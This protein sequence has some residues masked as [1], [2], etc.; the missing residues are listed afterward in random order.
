MTVML[1]LTPIWDKTR[2]TSIHLKCQLTFNRP[3]S[4]I[5]QKIE[6]LF[7]WQYYI[8]RHPSPYI[9]RVTKSTN[10]GGHMHWLEGSHVTS[11]FPVFC[12]EPITEHPEASHKAVLLQAI[13]LPFVLTSLGSHWIRLLHSGN[14]ADA[15][16]SWPKPP[17]PT[18]VATASGIW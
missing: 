7:S 5:S 15:T 10:W 14:V 8:L 16:T 3:H 18:A 6:H 4:M 17:S 13:G 2:I 1:C 9:V 12:C 11:Q